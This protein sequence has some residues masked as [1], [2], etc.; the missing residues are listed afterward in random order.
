MTTAILHPSATDPLN[1]TRY[2]PGQ[3]QGHYESFYQRANHPTKPW[4]FWIRYT[5]FSP[6][7][8]PES[9][10]G[11]IWAT[12]F[13]GETGEHFVAKEE[14]PL[15]ECRFDRHAFSARV[16]DRVLAPGSLHGSCSSFGDTLSWDLTYDGDEPPLYLLPRGFYQGS[17]PKAKSLVGMP[18]ATYQGELVVNGRKIDV[19]DWVGS[20]NHNWGSKHT[21]YYAFGQV[22][23]FDNAPASFLEIVSAQVKVGPVRTP[24][25]TFLVLRHEGREY[26][27]VSPLESYRA[28]ANFGYFHWDFASESKDV[29]IEGKIEAGAG[30]FVGLN[31]YNPPG[32]IK[33]C[34]NTKIGSCALTVLDKSTR[35]RHLLKTG[36]RALFEIL[37]DDRDHGITIRA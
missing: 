24:T 35:R 16:R 33:H 8:R 3:K 25:L 22:A 17:F 1:W 29:R 32:G 27:L 18:L 11:E 36:H 12:F 13:D 26:S 37:T 28:R 5:L 15:S 30:D 34:L 6:R 14:Y 19:S 21:D 4:A 31:Y 9:A 10:I 20:Q 23:G 7:S 2:L